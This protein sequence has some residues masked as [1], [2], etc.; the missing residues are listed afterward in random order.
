MCDKSIKLESKFKQFKSKTHKEFNKCKHLELTIE[1]PNTKDVDRFFYGYNIQHKKEYDYYLIKCRF[2]I[3]FSDNQYSTYV[4]SNLVDKKTI[5][6][7]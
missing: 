1:N 3:V 5:I 6:S 7:W 2:I 4:K